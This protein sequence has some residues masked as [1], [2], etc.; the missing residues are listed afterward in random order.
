MKTV[1]EF[2]K[3][4]K[5]YLIGIAIAV[6]GVLDGTGVFVIPEYVWPILA[7]AGLGALRSGISDI[8]KEVKK[9]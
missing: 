6:I 4:R 8:S 7:A 9:Q 3:G 5:S 1:I 2:L